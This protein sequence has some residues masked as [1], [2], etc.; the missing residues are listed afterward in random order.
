MVQSRYDD[1]DFHNHDSSTWLGT[2]STFDNDNYR[3]TSNSTSTWLGATF[4]YDNHRTISNSRLGTCSTIDYNIHRTTWLGTSS[5]INYNNHR[6]TSNSRLGTSTIYHPGTGNN[7][8]YDNKTTNARL[9]SV[10]RIGLGL[11]LLPPP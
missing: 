3:T 1:D 6:T 11:P 9:A 8:T 2:S 5:T 7:H 4:D 10:S